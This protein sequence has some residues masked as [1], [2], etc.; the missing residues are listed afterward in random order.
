[1]ELPLFL[2]LRPNIAYFGYP[3]LCIVLC[4]RFSI[5]LCSSLMYG[6]CE[7]LTLLK[8]TACRTTASRDTTVPAVR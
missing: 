5:L 2:Y 3:T 4:P 1:M 7:C 8:Q 6:D